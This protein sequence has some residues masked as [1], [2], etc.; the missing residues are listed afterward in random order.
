M[1]Q[2]AVLIWILVAIVAVLLFAFT[3]AVFSLVSIKAEL[4]KVNKSL[5]KLDARIAE[6]ERQIAEVRAA[7]SRSGGGDMFEPFLQAIQSFKSKGLVGALTL[8][9]SHLFRSY[10]GRRRQ[11]ALPKG[12]ATEE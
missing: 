6:Q 4:G 7:V 5:D 3:W 10:L 11:K 12:G 1:D 8:L 2:A 9:G